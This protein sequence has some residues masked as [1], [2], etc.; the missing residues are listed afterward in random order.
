MTVIGTD[1]SIYTT[2]LNQVDEPLQLSVL[3]REGKQLWEVGGICSNVAIAP[4]GTVYVCGRDG[5]V[6]AY[7]T[8]GQQK[9]QYDARADWPHY[10]NDMD[11]WLAVSPDGTVYALPLPSHKITGALYPRLLALT[12]SG[13]KKFHVDIP[14]SGWGDFYVPAIGPD[15]SFYVHLENEKLFKVDPSGNLREL[16]SVSGSFGSLILIDSMNT[17]YVGGWVP[18]HE[19]QTAGSI[20]SQLFAFRMDG[21]E[22]WRLPVEVSC[23]SL[24]MGSDGTIYVL[25]YDSHLYAVR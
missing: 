12:S 25:D 18:E 19:N 13:S 11:C 15:G 21:S 14:V 16:A 6:F 10:Y 7:D 20:K 2:C 17:I 3:S 8:Q 22:K 24:V 1:G 9:W 5:K 23:S 4:D